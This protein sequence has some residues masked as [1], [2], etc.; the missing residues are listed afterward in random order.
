MVLAE[1]TYF[2]IPQPVLHRSSILGWERGNLTSALGRRCT[3]CGSF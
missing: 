1:V 3:Y 2:T